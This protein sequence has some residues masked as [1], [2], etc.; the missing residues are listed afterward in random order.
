MGSEGRSMFQFIWTAKVYREGKEWVGKE[1]KGGEAGEKKKK[2]AVV[3]LYSKRRIL[4]STDMS[5]IPAIWYLEN[6]LHGTDDVT[7]SFPPPPLTNRAMGWFSSLSLSHFLFRC[8]ELFQLQLTAAI[9]P[10]GEPSKCPC[11][12]AARRNSA[13]LFGEAVVTLARVS[14]EL[15]CLSCPSGHFYS[16]FLFWFFLVVWIDP[17]PK[18]P[19]LKPHGHIYMEK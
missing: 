16:A 13:L 15:L 17:V 8:L 9:S 6:I 12:A 7:E 3:Y 2:S 5:F 4:W 19:M 14:V 1:E 11:L 18:E 10:S